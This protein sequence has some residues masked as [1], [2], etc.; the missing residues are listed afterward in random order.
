LKIKDD[1]RLGTSIRFLRIDDRLV[2][3]Q[4]IVGWVPHLATRAI[5]V[6]NDRVFSGSTRQ[7][8][9]RLSIPHD[10]EIQFHQPQQTTWVE[11][12]PMESLV[13]V[14]SPKDA[15]ACIQAGLLPETFNVGG[16]H[17]KPGKIEIFE[18][19][20]LDDGDRASFEAIISSGLKPIFQPTPQNEPV[21]ME[22]IL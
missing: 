8:M 13:L 1:T 21:P 9:M 20:H 14:S 6:A 5:I 18:A 17:A 19:L 10:V 15:L 22:D 4:V 16:M 2:H 12:L 11:G 7:E 3:G